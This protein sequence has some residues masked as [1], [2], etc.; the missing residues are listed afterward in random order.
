MAVYFEKWKESEREWIGAVVQRAKTNLMYAGLTFVGCIA[1]LGAIGFMGNGLQGM[2][3]NLGIGAVFGAICSLVFLI[4]MATNKV[5]KQHMQSI[6]RIMGKLNEEEKERF[7]IQM[8]E[9]EEPGSKRELVWTGEMK[10]NHRAC[11]TKDFITF[12]SD[13]GGM[14]FV[15]L[16]KVERIEL[17]VREDTIRASGGDMMMRIKETSYPMC[18]YYHQSVNEGKKDCD[19]WYVFETKEQ[20][21]VVLKCIQEMKVD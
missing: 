3:A 4:M 12:S 15:Q 7:A 20:R 13:R 16:D 9:I 6:D 18:F 17:E 11:V 21:D 5:D 14:S 19:A 10:I 8:L 1:G 2:I